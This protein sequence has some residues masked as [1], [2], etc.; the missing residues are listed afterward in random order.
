MVET[1]STAFYS[2]LGK[3]GFHHPVHV[4]LVHIPIGLL[5]GALILGTTAHLSGKANFH[6]CA[7]HCF[8]IVLI[9]FFPTVLT[10]IMDWS[11]RFDGAM[12]FPLQMKFM[13]A[14]ILFLLLLAGFYFGRGSQGERKCLLLIYASCFLLVSGIGYFGGEL[15]Y[16]QSPAPAK[17]YQTGQQIYAT[18]CSGCHPNGGNTID[19]KSPLKNS[20]KTSDYPVFLEWVRNP[21]APMPAF[22]P[23]VLTDQQ[24]SDLFDYTVN[25]INKD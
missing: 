12:L 22:P 17:Q 9:F 20:P 24:V 15:V 8:I 10:G 18:N 19:P 3:I 4:A 6:R 7:W 25:V 11:H 23:S 5:L 16:G 13:L 14:A 21:D 2:M 1:A